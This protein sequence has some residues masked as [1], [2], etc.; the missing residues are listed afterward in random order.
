[1]KIVRTRQYERDLRRLCLNDDDRDRLE[2]EIA[3]HPSA[4]VLIRGLHGLRKIRF[5]MRGRGKSG[6]GRAIYWVMT[7][8]QDGS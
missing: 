8:E 1:M 4:G 5:A 7:W 6:G 2:L 3:L